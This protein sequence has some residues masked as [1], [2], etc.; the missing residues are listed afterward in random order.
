[1]IK[2]KEEQ[3]KS[4][5]EY[6]KTATIDPDKLKKFKKELYDAFAK[7]GC[8][9]PIANKLGIYNDLTDQVPGIKVLSWGYNQVNEK[10]ALVKDWHVYYLDWG[11]QY[12][13]DMASF[14]DQ[15]YSPRSL[16]CIFKH[17]EFQRH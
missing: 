2:V 11:E 15:L 12:G 4:E 16:T 17:L 3:E 5:E 9:R 14:E 1:M 6:L 10:A 13:R 7:S 8:L